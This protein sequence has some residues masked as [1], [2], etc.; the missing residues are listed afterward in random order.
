MDKLLRRFGIITQD[1]DNASFC[2]LAM[3]SFVPNDFGTV[4]IRTMCELDGKDMSQIVIEPSGSPFTELFQARI[5]EMNYFLKI[6]PLF[7]PQIKIDYGLQTE[8]A[9]QAEF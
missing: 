2:I 7:N 9:P 6:L 1:E 8:Q 3:D 4:I 5:G